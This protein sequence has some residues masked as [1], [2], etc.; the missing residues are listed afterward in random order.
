MRLGRICEKWI[1]PQYV[2]RAFKLLN[3]NK[4][5]VAENKKSGEG[6]DFKLTH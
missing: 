2:I 5:Y 1:C 4:K 6:C 3:W